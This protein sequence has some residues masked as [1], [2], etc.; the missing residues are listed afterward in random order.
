VLEPQSTDSYFNWNFFDGILQ[1]KEYFDPYLF[2]DLADSLL[3][4]K[5]GLRKE[6][7]EMK[8]EDSLFRNDAQAQLEFIYSN[9]MRELEFMRYPVGR[10]MGE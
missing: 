1:Q 10:I 6:F 2:E 3:D 4:S 7:E 9:T 8:K 5:P